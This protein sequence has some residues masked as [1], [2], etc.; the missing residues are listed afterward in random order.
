M[1]TRRDLLKL[2]GMLAALPIV[3]ETAAAA[4]QSDRWQLTGREINVLSAFDAV[5]QD[6]MAIRNIRGAAFA[7]TWQRRLMTARGYNYGDDLTELVVPTSLFR[8][9]SLSKP[10]T[11]TAI[12]QLIEQRRLTLNTR[13]T[14]LLT[15]TP[16]GNYRRDPRWDDITILNLLQ[17]A[18]GFDRQA[19]ADPMF[20]DVQIAGQ[21]GVD[22]PIS[23]DHIVTYM[24]GQTLDFDPGTRYAY[25]NFGYELL[26]LALETVTGGTYQDYVQA[27]ILAPLGI[28]DMG[29]AA[30][31]ASGRLANEVSYFNGSNRLPRVNVVD[32]SATATWP[33]GGYNLEN[34][35]GSAGWLSSVVDMARFMTAYDDIFQSPLL[36]PDSIRLMFR[37]PSFGQNEYGSYYACGWDVRPMGAWY[38]TWHIGSLAGVFTLML[39]R[40]DGLNWVVFFNQ[41]RDPSG[42]NYYD[43]DP[44]LY[45]TAAALT[46][47]P[48]HDL[49]ETYFPTA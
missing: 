43:I 39:R 24:A 34:M 5:I 47:V 18:G 42:E 2:A 33:Y 29:L 1:L 35:V 12:L 48:D 26:R 11:A 22:L 15:I 36:S 32:P 19:S 10:I 6:F 4:A 27:N 23:I 8:I 13:I 37:E 41:R 21:L 49:F 20:R 38:N 44:L 7:L 17:H 16:D 3:G 46:T 45:E 30:S 25:S 40:H 14:N 28:A 9:A 31:L